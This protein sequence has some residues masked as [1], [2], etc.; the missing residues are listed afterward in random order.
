MTD[1]GPVEFLTHADGCDDR[2]GD[3]GQG[4]ASRDGQVPSVTRRLL[5][6]VVGV[7]LQQRRE[8]KRD[9]SN[10]WNTS[11]PKKN[12]GRLLSREQNLCQ[13]LSRADEAAAFPEKIQ[14]VI[15]RLGRPNLRNSW[16]RF[17]TRRRQT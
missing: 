1:E 16:G 4:H 7:D 12:N 6:L 8:T 9:D 10:T 2:G 17:L 3:D 13:N 14:L 15:V 5:Q 11:E